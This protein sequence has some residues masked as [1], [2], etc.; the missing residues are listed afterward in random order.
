MKHAFEPIMA[1][2]HR[3]NETMQKEGWIYEEERRIWRFVGIKPTIQERLAEMPATTK[4]L[5]DG[6][7]DQFV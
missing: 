3:F 2:L 5:V 7:A 4:A 1:G 6:I